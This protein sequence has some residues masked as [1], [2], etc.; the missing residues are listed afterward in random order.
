MIGFN[1]V[2][3]EA[4]KNQHADWKPVVKKSWWGQK[5]TISA[6]CPMYSF[7]RRLRIEGDKVRI[8]DRIINTANEPLGVFV[9]HMVAMG[10]KFKKALIGSTRVS[11]G[12][13]KGTNKAQG[14]L[15]VPK[16]VVGPVIPRDCKKQLIGTPGDSKK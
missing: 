9:K 14:I 10:Q 3:S 11:Q 16:M 7:E 4:G 5:A 15:E 6:K 2:S 13:Q 8:Y 12:F 1:A